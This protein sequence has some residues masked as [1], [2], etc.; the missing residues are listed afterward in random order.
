MRFEEMNIGPSVL[1]AV[2]EQRY[3]RPTAIQGAVIPRAMGGED[4]IGCSATGSGKTA[5]FAIP[6]LEKLE[7]KGG[8]QALILAP[9]R[10]LAIQIAAMVGALGKYR[11]VEVLPVYGGQSMRAQI[12][13]LRRTEV[14]VGTPGRLLDHLR[15]GT[16]S[17]GKVRTLVIDEADRMLDM[18]FLPDVEA[19]IRETPKSRQTMLFSAT[20]PEEVQRLG[21]RHMR[22]PAYF[23]AEHKEEKPKIEQACIETAQAEKFQTLIALL[24]K[25]KPSSAIIFCNT[26]RMTSN[27]ARQIS[28]GRFQACAVHGDLTQNQRERA[29]RGFREGEPGILV[30]TDVASRG[31]DIEGV[32]HIF[33]Y[34]IPRNPQDY[35]H[36][37]GRT[38]RA[39]REGKAFSILC[40]R[41]RENMMKVER[42]Y[43]PL[44]RYRLP[45]LRPSPSGFR[46]AEEDIER[47]TRPRRQRPRRW[48]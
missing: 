22:N 33:N 28:K 37:I 12:S 36:R 34:D 16:M 9:T 48:N 13:A 42:Y 40:P 11:G 39:G 46:V 1:K 8:I 44:A 17:L 15:R 14:V 3:E 32:S 4:V 10:E 38:G 23:S 5:A 41:D 30:A 47:P 29:I 7:R 2:R 45:G 35:V 19:I 26:K 43:R 31:L 27:L 21:R 25:E 24:E 6:I 18:G 20:M